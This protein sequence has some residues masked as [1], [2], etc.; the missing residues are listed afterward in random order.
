MEV[1]LK[2]RAGN[3]DSARTIIIKT[4]EKQNF[5]PAQ[6]NPQHQRVSSVTVRLNTK[7]GAKNAYLN[8]SIGNPNTNGQYIIEK[9]DKAIVDEVMKRFPANKSAGANVNNVMMGLD[10]DRVNSDPS[11]FVRFLSGNKTINDS[12]PVNVVDSAFREELM[13]SHKQLPFTILFQKYSHDNTRKSDF[14]TDSSDGVITSKVFVGFNTPYSY[15]AAFDNAGPYVLKKMSVQISGSLLLLLLVL[16]SFITLYRNLMAQHRL[17]LIKND[18]ISNITHE[19]KTPIAT[20]N[21]AIEALRNFGGLQSPERTKEY[22][23]ISASELQRLSLLVDKVLKLSLFEN[24]EIIL[25]KESFDL[26]HLIGEVLLSMKLQF[27]KQKA[28]TAFEI[29]GSKFM[30]D[31]DKMHISSVVYNLLDNALKYAVEKPEINIKLIR[32]E[33]FFELRVTDNGM[34]IPETYQSRI[35][36]QFFRVPDGNR[37]NTKGYGLGLSYVKHILQMHHGIIEV[38]SESGKGS[39]FIVKIPFADADKVDFGDGRKIFRIKF[40]SR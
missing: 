19:L 2:Q 36:E 4:G 18:F 30:L 17:T 27:E 5:N 10:T 33:S 24:K 20:V 8:D 25:Q 6:Y 13:K 37:H 1:I 32:Q 3:H 26:Q 34:G 7:D 38:K 31:A 39:T 9:A 12:I 23:D 11:P 22:L 21:V 16:I 14:E 15:Q 40:K 29:S 28:V 35:F